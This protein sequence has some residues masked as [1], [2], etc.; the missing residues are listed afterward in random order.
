MD[1]SRKGR[2]RRLA[3]LMNKQNEIPLPVLPQLLDCFD[4]VITDPEADFMI[5]MG[6]KTHTYKE[7]AE[8]AGADGDSFVS[9][10]DTLCRKGLVWF[11]DDGAKGRAYTLAPILVGWFELTLARARE[12]P[13]EIEF[14]KRLDALFSA[15]KKLNIFP[16]RGATNL[17][18]RMGT[19]PFQSI[20]PVLPKKARGGNKE[21]VPVNK[22]LS[23]PPEKIYPSSMVFDI[24]QKSGSENALGV[25]HCFCRQWRKMVGEP[26]R[27]KLPVE[28]CIVLG[29]FARFT[30]EMG[31]ARAITVEEACDIV[32]RVQKAGGVHQVFH[33]KDDTRFERVAICNCCWDCCGV[34]G[35]HNRGVIPLH[36]QCYAKARVDESL[37]T[38]CGVCEKFCPSEAMK[39][40]GEKANLTEA[41]CIGCGQ[42]AA[43]CPTGAASMEACE[44]QVMLPLR[45]VSQVRIP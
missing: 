27:F 13:E 33:E 2:L 19:R 36:F 23:V 12:T 6:T 37:C 26:C 34:I 4:L 22:S 8:L 20:A 30:S 38:G 16:I 39:V 40:T 24:I 15:F 21:L 5:K 28:A 9:F 10:L 35:S 25:M 43:K 31:I 17:F 3:R 29:D 32:A 45:S 41:L 11:K 42:C 7:L 14:A 44:R 18:V 1:A